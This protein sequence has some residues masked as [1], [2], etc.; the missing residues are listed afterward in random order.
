MRRGNSI[1]VC[2]CVCVCVVWTHIILAGY[3]EGIQ[4]SVSEH[5]L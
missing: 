4:Y 3:I 1:C 2:V 5:K